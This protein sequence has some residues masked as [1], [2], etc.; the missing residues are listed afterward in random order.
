[1]QNTSRAKRTLLHMAASISAIAVLSATT[2]LPSFAETERHVHFGREHHVTESS[3]QVPQES[4]NQAMQAA[5]DAFNRVLAPFARITPEAAKASALKEVKGSQVQEITLHVM[6]QNLVYIALLTK[7]D[8]RYMVIIDAGNGK[9]LGM[10]Q[11]H[12]KHHTKHF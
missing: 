4:V 10:R 2:A 5:R 7:P 1:M 6:R 11:M 9:I 12:M 3:V 8:A